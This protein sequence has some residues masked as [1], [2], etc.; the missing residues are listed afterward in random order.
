MRVKREGG[1][2]SGRERPMSA[3]P[4][5]S[6]RKTRYFVILFLLIAFN[7]GFTTVPWVWTQ[8]RLLGIN[9]NW[10][11]AI[12]AIYAPGLTLLLVWFSRADRATKRRVL[13]GDLPCWNCGYDLRATDSPGK[14]PECGQDFE[15]AALREKWTKYLEGP[16]Q[17]RG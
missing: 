12:W 9:P 16:K 1:D 3:P 8:L 15:S 4:F 17:T 5:L 7:L 6:W 2:A 10:R 13:G 11:H 14:C